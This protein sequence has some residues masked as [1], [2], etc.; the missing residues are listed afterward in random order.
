MSRRVRELKLL[1]DGQQSSPLK[2][3]LGANVAKLLKRGVHLLD[4]RLKFF[5]SRVRVRAATGCPVAPHV[6]S[7]RSFAAENGLLLNV[8]ESGRFPQPSCGG[9]SP[10]AR[11][12]S[13]DSG[14]C[15]V[16]GRDSS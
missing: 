7:L 6:P 4:E 2:L 12:I 3:K 8:V 11:A 13:V 1:Y 15:V 10:R 9:S 16:S 5:V 14:G